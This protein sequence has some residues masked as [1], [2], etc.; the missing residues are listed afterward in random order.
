MAMYL[1]QNWNV[2]LFEYLYD[3]SV[4]TPIFFALL[5][6][7][8][9]WFSLRGTNRIVLV[10]LNLLMLVF[11]AIFTFVAIFGFQNP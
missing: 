2:F 9:A 1:F 6:F 11:F 5:G 8:C 7:I 10:I 4:F 3:L